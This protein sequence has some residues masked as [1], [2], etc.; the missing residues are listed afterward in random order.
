M[1]PHETEE[2]L[3]GKDAIIQTMEHPTGR[4]KIFTN[5]T[6]SRGLIFK[7]YKEQKK[8]HLK[9]Q[10]IHLKMWYRNKKEFSKKEIKMN[11]K[12]FLKN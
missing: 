1:E 2:L 12:H 3:H 10:M 5:C 9:K 11:K 4:E 8:L 6:F 7:K